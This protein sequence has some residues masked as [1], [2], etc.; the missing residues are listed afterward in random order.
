LK[1]GEDA[2]ERL[3]AGAADAEEK[4]KAGAAAEERLKAG[5]ADAKE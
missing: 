3:K 2:E 5:A 4:L 1:A